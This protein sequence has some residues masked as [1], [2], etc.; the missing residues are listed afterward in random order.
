[1]EDYIGEFPTTEYSNLKTAELALL[2]IASYG[3]IDGNHH[4]D[5]VLDQVARVLNDTPVIVTE[6]RWEN[7][8]TEIRFRTG[9]PS[10]R[11]LEWVRK[12]KDG[13]DGP[14]TYSYDCGIAP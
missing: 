8:T 9:E 1:M 13:E 6:A 2:F 7:G 14:D 10:V 4:K 11:Y 12:C 3:S 5:W